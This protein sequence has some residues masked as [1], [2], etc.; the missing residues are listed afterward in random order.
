[1]LRRREIRGTTTIG[2]L[3]FAAGLATLVAVLWAATPAGAQ[4]DTTGG[5]QAFA[6]GYRD[7]DDDAPGRFALPLAGVGFDYDGDGSFSA[8][9]SFPVATDVAAGQAI[10]PA[11]AAGDYVVRT[12]TA[13]S[14]WLPLRTLGAFGSDQPYVGTATV[15]AGVTSTAMIDDELGELPLFVAAAE[16]PPL[17]SSCGTGLRVLLLLDTSG[18]TADYRAEYAAAARTFVSTLAGTP[19]SLR[20][21]TFATDSHAGTATY[22]LATGVGQAAADSEID[23]VYG[24]DFDGG[25]T[26]WDAAFQDAALA[27]VDVIVF[28]TDG[29]PTTHVIGDGTGGSGGGFDDISYGIASANLAKHPQRDPAG[30]RQRILGVGVG[31][32]ISVANLAAVSGPVAGS[33]YATAAGPDQLAVTLAAVA[34]SICPTQ[35]AGTAPTVIAPPTATPSRVL[36]PRIVRGSARIYGD[37]GCTERRVVTSTVRGSNIAGVVF[38]RDGIVVKRM[39]ADPMRPQLFSLRTRLARDDYDL[40]T[41]VARVRYIAAAQPAQK[42]MVHRFLRCRA[43]AVTG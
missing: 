41:V 17:P 14:G 20:I 10:V 5:L 38:R 12:S 16:N 27:A 32:G 25:L 21:S 6:G 19:T 33:D 23:R 22:D 9:A 28:V 2:R 40:H 7:T 30:L 43:S 8:P 11:L 29:A 37:A 1:M 39:A 13:P 15:S 4:S 31:A 24:P 26:N 34:S 18:S 3:A 36:P 35:L 42:L